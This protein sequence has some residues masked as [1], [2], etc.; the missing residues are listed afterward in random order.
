[1]ERP[2]HLAHAERARRIRRWIRRGEARLVT[3]H[4]ALRHQDAIGASL[5]LLS[6]AGMVGLGALYATAR[7][8]AFVCVLGCAFFASVL[9]EI[10]HDLIHFLYFKNRPLVHN[11]MMLLVWALR[12]NV[13]HGWYRRGIHFHHHRASGTATDV[14]ERLLGLGQPWG[15]R[16]LVVM[17]DGAMAFLLN[18]RAL[19]K[20]VPGFDR[21]AL[22][23]AS[24]PF[25]PVFAFVLLSYLVSHA[26]VALVPG[27]VPSAWY[28]SIAPA[29]DVLAIGWVFPNYIRQAALQI[30]S[31]NVHYY[32]DVKGVDQETQILRPAFL[33]PLQVFCFNFGTTHSFH[34]YVV[35][36]P[37]YLRQLLCPWVL[38]AM[39]KYGVRFDDLG[40]FL[41]ANRFLAA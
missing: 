5:C 30:V 22:A 3:R 39:R 40:T 15:P 17:I 27:Y 35:D 34:H 4:P 13:V 36:Q 2:S 20:E 24:L 26:L 16:R 14:E 8:P 23:L 18:A 31:S 37:F 32:E 1:M 28:S 29:V 9:H 38:P 33:W 21:R 25:Y 12:G 7:V 10:E 6:I 41:R 19:E 11:V